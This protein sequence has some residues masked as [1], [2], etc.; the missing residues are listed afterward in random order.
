MV[1]YAEGVRDDMYDYMYMNSLHQKFFK[2]PA[3][4]ELRQEISDAVLSLEG[5]LIRPNTF[6]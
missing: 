2:E 3:C 1:V 4:G 5:Y 6:W